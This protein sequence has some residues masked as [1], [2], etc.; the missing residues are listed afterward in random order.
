[1]VGQHRQIVRVEQRPLDR[2][3]EK[4]ARV[5]DQI[6]VERKRAGDQHRDRSFKPSPGPP[7]LLPRAGDSARIASHHAG[8]ELPNV[9]PQ[10]ERVGRHDGAH[11]PLPQSLLNG[12]PLVGKV[13]TPIALHRLGIT[14]LGGDRIAQV[15]Q[16]NLGGQ[17]GAGKD[18]GLHISLEEADSD[19]LRRQGGAAPDAELPIHQR[20][21]VEDKVLLPPWSAIVVHQRDRGLDEFLGQ[22]A[23]VGDGGG[24]ANKAGSRA[25]EATHPPQSP[26]H[27][28][29]VPAKDTPVG[30][31][32]IKHDV[33][34]VAKEP[35]PAGMVGQDAS[36]EHVGVGDQQTG[37][38]ADGGTVR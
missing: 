27:V 20:G 34:Q 28:R 36:V 26:Q 23:R 38:A 11:F 13:A 14:P 10:L 2:L 19:L 1:M 21:V 16:H 6:L 35:R 30:V 24:G 17:P 32:L 9:Y 25:I 31:K 29:H 18:N 37:L 8:V 3:A 12:A 7:G 22:L 5:R 15:A 4:V 33:A